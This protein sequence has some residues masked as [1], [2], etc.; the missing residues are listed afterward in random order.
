MVRQNETYRR[1]KRE[2]DNVVMSVYCRQTVGEVGVA[3]GGVQRGGGALGAAVGVRAVG[4]RVRARARHHARAAHHAV[5]AHDACARAP[6]MC[7]SI[8]FVVYSH[9][10]FDEAV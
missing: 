10:P 7:H 2:K 6:R 4:A 8:F 5:G 1:E 9:I 3:G